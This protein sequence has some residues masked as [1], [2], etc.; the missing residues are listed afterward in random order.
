MK[1]H[2]ANIDDV[3][4]NI[5]PHWQGLFLYAIAIVKAEVPIGQGQGVVVEMLEYGARCQALIA[6]GE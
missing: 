1:E 4:I 5:E 6:G 3:S 2:T